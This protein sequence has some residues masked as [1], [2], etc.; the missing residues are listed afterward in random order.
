MK[1]FRACSEK[2]FD[3]YKIKEL[4]TDKVVKN[5]YKN[6]GWGIADRFYIRSAAQPE[7]EAR[8]YP[9]KTDTKAKDH[10]KKRTPDADSYGSEESLKQQIGGPA[11]LLHIKAH[12]IGGDYGPVPLVIERIEEAIA[13]VGKKT[14]DGCEDNTIE[15]SDAFFFMNHCDQNC[16]RPL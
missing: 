4:I 1:S 11:L 7:K 9:H 2:I 5:K 13:D 10:R 6:K 15:N 14:Y 12:Q 8:R 16:S 3:T